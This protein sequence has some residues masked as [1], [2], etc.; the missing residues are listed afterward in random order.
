MIAMTP[1]LEKLIDAAQARV[2]PSR[3]HKVAHGASVRGRGR[4]R[5]ASSIRWLPSHPTGSSVG[6][7]PR[8]G[9]H[10]FARREVRGCRVRDLSDGAPPYIPL[11]R[12]RSSSRV[13][14]VR[15]AYSSGNR[16]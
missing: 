10:W 5:I 7:V 2:S 13:A 15:T 1:E 16:R 4:F 3:V 14:W 8:L 9:Q 11:I 6:C 12:A